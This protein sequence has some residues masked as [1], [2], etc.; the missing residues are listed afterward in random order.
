MRGN[1]LARGA[2]AVVAVSVAVTG[3]VAQQQAARGAVTG[4]SFDQQAATYAKSMEGVRYV[5]GGTSRAGI[6]CSGLTQYVYDH[7]GRPIGRTAEDQFRQFRPV[8]KAQASPGDL[9]FFHVTSDPDS[10]VYHV[11]VYEG[12]DDMVAASSGAG[13]VIWESLAWAGDTVTYGTITHLPDSRLPLRIPAP[14]FR[15]PRFRTWFRTFRTRA[16]AE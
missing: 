5:Y 10:Y 2:L 11:A 4:G 1:R 7:L 13:R 12:G 9:V 6:D 15:T 8:S 14:R 3:T 16:T